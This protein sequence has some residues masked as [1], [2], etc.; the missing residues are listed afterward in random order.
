MAGENTEMLTAY[1]A[2]LN[3][4][5][6]EGGDLLEFAT[7]YVEPD[8]VAEL[9]VMEGTVSGGPEGM[10][11]YFEG[12]RAVIDDLRIDPEEF[13]EVADH[14]V[15]PFRLHGR[16]KETGLPIEFR[17]TQLFKMRNGR[18]AHARMY[19]SKEKALAALE[20]AP[21]RPARRA[22]SSGSSRR[23]RAS[24]AGRRTRRGCGSRASPR[25]TAAG[26]SAPGSRSPITRPGREC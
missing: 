11:R 5:F 3:Q 10:A 23:R 4:V 12:Q 1:F 15:M 26:S 22:S 18:F 9:G 19:A 8:C 13:I 20:R 2:K 16:A 17:Y 6:A 7:P 25:R 24:A 21:L 14:V